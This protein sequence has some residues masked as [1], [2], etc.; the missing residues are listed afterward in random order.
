M[1][2]IKSG[3]RTG[4]SGGHLER[5]RDMF[6]RRGKEV[7]AARGL[8]GLKTRGRRIRKLGET[9]AEAARG[10]CGAVARVVGKRSRSGVPGFSGGGGEL[11][12]RPT[13]G[14]NLSS[15]VVMRETE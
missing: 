10:H 8:P 11:T 3:E 9:F 15:Y 12:S 2:L 7:A 4:Q 14:Y 6:R 5:N 13:Y 1:R